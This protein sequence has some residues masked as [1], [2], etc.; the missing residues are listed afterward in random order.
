MRFIRVVFCVLC[1]L[2]GTTLA[3][4][5]AIPFVNLALNPTSVTPGSQAFTL[6]VTGTGFAPTAVLKWNRSP[7]LTE[8]I[9]STELK[10]TINAVDVAK[11]RTASVT[12]TNPPPGGGTSSAVFFPIRVPSLAVAMTGKQVFSGATVT[13]VGDFNNDGK[14]DVVW[15]GNGLL[16]VSFGNGNGT[17]QAPISTTVSQFQVDQL[18]AG[19]FNG[20]GNLDVVAIESMGSSWM[21]QIYLGNGNGTLTQSG[22]IGTSSGGGATNF[23]IS[24]DFN[25]DGYSDL[26]L[27]AS[28]LGSQWFSILLGIGDGTFSY[29][30]RYQEQWVGGYGRAA[31][32][33]FNG[34]GKLDIAAPDWS[35][36]EIFLGNGDGNFQNPTTTFGGN[37]PYLITADMNHDGKLDLILDNCIALGKGD[38]TFSFARCGA[39]SGQTAAVGDFNGDGHL[40]VAVTGA[41]L[42]GAGDGTFLNSFRI[43]GGGAGEVGDFN[44]DAMLDMI[45]PNG[46]LLLQTTA[47]LSPASLVFGNQNVGTKSSPQTATLTNVGASALVIN[48]I[49]IAG[50]GYAN[51]KQTNNCGLSLPAETSC[52]INVTFNPKAVGTFS[53]SVKVSYKG[54]GSP[55]KIALSGTGVTA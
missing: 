39:Y 55:L 40:D 54:V 17:F 24:A 12:V 9:S 36:T 50:T 4:S 32:G 34:D 18:I 52:T 48:G 37:D 5:N 22:A 26:Y 46:V 28:N 14:L 27:T 42:L 23:V 13:A 20:D 2:C 53:P 10:A 15:Y 21:G 41:I 3:Q 1:V 19:D 45:S 35:T 7:R 43:N 44:N 51:F 29:G 33:D 8:V 16:N 11:A 47:G 6:T 25:H 49:S 38:G 30:W 31:V